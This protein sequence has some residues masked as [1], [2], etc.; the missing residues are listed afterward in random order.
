MSDKGER[1]VVIPVGPSTKYNVSADAFSNNAFNPLL[2]LRPSQ[3]IRYTII[4]LSEQVERLKKS[5]RGCRVSSSPSAP[6][7]F[8]NTCLGPVG[9]QVSVPQFPTVAVDRVYNP[10]FQIHNNHSSNLV[11]SSS[12]VRLIYCL[13][14]ENW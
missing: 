11:N 6:K 10:A 8:E 3:L 7:S 2:N 5:L 14:P 13:G 1:I 12:A 9:H 4:L